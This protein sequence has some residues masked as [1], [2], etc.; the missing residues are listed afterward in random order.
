M[1]TLANPAQPPVP[2]TPMDLLQP[3]RASTARSDADRAADA[4]RSDFSDRLDRERASDRG[5]KAD[6]RTESR[7]ND[8][9]ERSDR[10]DRPERQDQSQHA[11]D[12]KANASAGADDANDA[13]AP[14]T[15]T[16][17]DAASSQDSE[18]TAQQ[19]S[20]SIDSGAEEDVAEE[21]QATILELVE[22][23]RAETESQPGGL[24]LVGLSGETIELTQ[25]TTPLAGAANP[26]ELGRWFMEASGPVV[27]SAQAGPA[28]QQ[29]GLLNALQN[30]QLTNLAST[31]S[32]GVPSGL[33][34]PDG[35]PLQAGTNG[36]ANGTTGDGTL[37]QAGQ[38]SDFADVLA[39]SNAQ[40][41]TLDQFLGQAM[42]KTSA[43]DLA[44]QPTQTVMTGQSM[45]ASAQPMASAAP[46]ASTGQAVPVTA[47]AVEITRQAVNGKTQFDIRLD[48]PE[49]GRLNVRLEMDASGQTRTHLVVERSE[50]LEMLMTDAR[51]LERALQQ[52]GLKADPG[53]VS[54]EL[55][56]DSNDGLGQNGDQAS[57]GDGTQ[58]DTN[59]TLL[60]EEAGADDTLPV[61]PEAMRYQVNVTGHLDVRV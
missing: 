38:S 11:S 19:D 60:G 53:S 46:T 5:D 59:E 33:L 29:A 27:Q 26:G 16:D 36:Q 34:G 2:T 21:S 49:L 52:A 48:P 45:A 7:A 12:S 32:N 47:L 4:G 54:F 58:P 3:S 40:T 30:G 50:T 10:S 1:S 56:Q 6:S 23:L 24:T 51:N 55:A 35:Q 43:A 42:A 20:A 31:G 17:R 57:N 18:G 37:M 25:P 9:A 44:A 15:E 13:S 14:A 39:Q 41:D 28:A 22:A 61:S 8:R